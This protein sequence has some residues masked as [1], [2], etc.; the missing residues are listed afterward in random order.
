MS[1]AVPPMP[2]DGWCIRIC[3]VRQRVP[4]ARR[5]RGQQ[6]LAH[7]RG[8]AHRVGGHVVGDVLHDVVDGHARVDRAARGVDVEA[9]VALGVLGGEQQELGADAVGDVV[10]HLLA[11]EDDAVPQQPLEQLIPQR[12][13]RRLRLAPR[14]MAA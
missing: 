4:L 2:P 13:E 12:Q 7:R 9:D 8:H 1:D 5:A 14:S 6:E 3:G 10:V 11:E